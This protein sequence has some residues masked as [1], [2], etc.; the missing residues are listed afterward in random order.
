MV[1]IQNRQGYKL[2]LFLLVIILILPMII[3]AG[4]DC[5]KV[6]QNKADVNKSDLVYCYGKNVDE[7]T[8]LPQEVQESYLRKNSEQFLNGLSESM[9]EKKVGK[10]E[11]KKNL[12]KLVDSWT[13]KN[14]KGNLFSDDVKNKIWNYF[15]KAGKQ[16]D[17]L[18][19]VANKLFWQKYDSVSKSEG[20]K[21]P[22]KVGID[23]VNLNDKDGKLIWKGN[24]L[25]L[26]DSKGEFTGW[27][28]LEN[29]ARWLEKIDFKDGEFSLGFDTGHGKKDRSFSQGTIGKMGELIGSDGKEIG[30]RMNEGL[31]GME[32]KDNK[33]VCTYKIGEKEKT[34]SI[35]PSDLGEELFTNLKD[36]IKKGAT[37]FGA[38][39]DVISK[40]DDITK[41]KIEEALKEV[42]QI[43]VDFRS[44]DASSQSAFP[45]NNR[46]NVL[47]GEGDNQMKIGY[48]EKGN[49]ELKAYNGAMAVT[50]TLQGNVNLAVK[51]WSL[52]DDTNNNAPEAGVFKF[53]KYG[54]LTAAQNT[55]FSLYNKDGSEF[56]TTYLSRAEL[57][58]VNILENSFANAL[59]RGDMKAVAEAVL[60]DTDIVKKTLS[61]TENLDV[62]AE[63]L[64]YIRGQLKSPET[65]VELKNKLNDV[66]ASVEKNYEIGAGN[67]MRYAIAGNEKLTAPDQATVDSASREGVDLIRGGVSQFLSDTANVESLLKGE[68]GGLN[69]FLNA[70][71]GDKLSDS[72]ISGILSND[73]TDAVRD[74]ASKVPASASLLAK[75]NGDID[76]EKLIEESKT[77][78]E[79]PSQSLGENIN[80]KLKE[81]APQ[82]SETNRNAIVNAVTS[83]VSEAE[84]K[85]TQERDAFRERMKKDMEINS[86]YK[87]Q[88]TID[89]QLKEVRVESDKIV[90]YDAKT[91][92]SS[93]T[94]KSTKTEKSDVG[95][96]INLYS[97]GR[98][99]M[100][101]DGDKT[102]SPGLVQQE[103][104]NP[105]GLM[106]NEKT[107]ESWTLMDFGEGYKIYDPKEAVEKFAGW[108]TA[109]VT[110][111]GIPILGSVSIPF[112]TT[113]NVIR[114]SLTGDIGADP[115]AAISITYKPDTDWGP[116]PG[117]FF[118]GRIVNR[119]A[120]KKA[121]E[122]AQKED[123]KLSEFTDKLSSEIDGQYQQKIDRFGGEA[124]MVKLLE[125]SRNQLQLAD[126]FNVNV[127]NRLELEDNL[128]LGSKV[129]QGKEAFK[130]E[131]DKVLGPMSQHSIE[132]GNNFKITNTGVY[133]GENK[134]VDAS[135]D[136]GMQ[137]VLRTLVRQISG[138]PSR[139]TEHQTRVK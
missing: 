79:N 12:D 126:K 7:F 63:L 55:I 65:S 129:L 54:E 78:S 77:K 10:D 115:N 105:I 5:S 84:A 81:S 106:I 22:S 64:N 107:G 1:I 93:F 56:G 14:D 138:N 117:R 132:W 29:S 134:V 4:I 137:V 116:L 59:I 26:V 71:L 17:F 38:G 51:P 44:A 85:V 19:S 97:N 16:N 73:I 21:D 57:I 83:L 47:W 109:T 68:K 15:S 128:Y 13:K 25:G 32:F 118:V 28:D 108:G 88:I 86:P 52:K 46:L 127:P 9:D 123:F 96:V 135:N 61:S 23:S 3:G 94:A 66:L 124:N 8:K 82:L 11:A 133:V 131:F 20:W 27:V 91:Q 114:G 100:T 33:F 60:K 31:T 45:T 76:F 111:N 58:G 98:P 30:A 122:E 18:K 75:V 74:I 139:L 41:G 72:S 48:D 37:N 6:F 104:Y 120:N 101:F 34:I 24:K 80:Q 121:N 62:K 90:I 113:Y 35:G 103:N 42:G 69:K 50:T 130:A 43:G 87:N 112:S 92:L 95:S 70:Y 67:L 136:P 53:N 110:K 39:Q 125:Q 2:F 40:I 99:V 102:Y 49:P 89:E 119:F 36:S